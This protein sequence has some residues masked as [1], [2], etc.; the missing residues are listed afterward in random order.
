MVLVAEFPKGYSRP[1]KGTERSTQDTLDL[2]KAQIG[3]PKLVGGVL[4]KNSVE[5]GCL[6]PA[7]LWDC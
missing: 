4:M 5:L 1:R 3:A 2:E 6:L 7:P